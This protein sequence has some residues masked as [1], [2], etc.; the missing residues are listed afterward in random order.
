MKKKNKKIFEEWLE[1]SLTRADSSVKTTNPRTLDFV[2]AM[3]EK[4]I[5]TTAIELYKKE[6]KGNSDGETKEF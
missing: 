1:A 4:R 2:V 6:T 3:V 5:F